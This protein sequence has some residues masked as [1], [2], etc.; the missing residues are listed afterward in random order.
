MKVIN[1]RWV[2]DQGEA[3]TTPD[4]HNKF[5]DTLMRV[6]SFSQSKRLT[7][8]KV[9][10]LFRILSTNNDMDNALTSVLSMD[11]QQLK[12]LF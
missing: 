10:V 11:N 5:Q 1:G 12:R 2:N 9:Q 4:E 3:L 6:K 7:D 8:R